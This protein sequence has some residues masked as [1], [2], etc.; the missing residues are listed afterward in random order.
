MSIEKRLTERLIGYWEKLLSANP[1]FNAM[2][3]EGAVARLP[4]YE[5]FNKG[6]IEDVW[7][8]CFVLRVQ[9]GERKILNY[10]YEY[11][12]RS[13][14]DVYGRDL[15]NM[16]LNSRMQNVPGAKM[17]KRIDEISQA[18]VPITDEGQFVNEKHN[19]VKYRACMLPFTRIGREEVTHIVAGLSWRQF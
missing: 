12:G 19:T 2:P 1:E 9:P 3:E 18:K 10:V 7:A 5:H 17:L 6:L 4:D 13:L 8:S 11:M 14:I 15:T 16:T